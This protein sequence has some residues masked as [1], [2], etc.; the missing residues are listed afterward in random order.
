MRSEIG[1]VVPKN[2]LSVSRAGTE[3]DSGIKFFF[4]RPR[5]T[6]VCFCR[7]VVF[8]DTISDRRETRSDGVRPVPKAVEL[9]SFVVWTVDQHLITGFEN[10]EIQLL[11]PY[12]L[13]V[14]AFIEIAT[15]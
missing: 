1:S 15:G 7:F 13:F 6:A 14:R 3:D 12:R 4:G 10:E 11:S 2:M 9:I 8:W 5:W